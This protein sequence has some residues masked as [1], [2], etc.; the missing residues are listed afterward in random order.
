MTPEEAIRMSVTAH[1][2]N[3]SRKVLLMQLTNPADGFRC[4][5]CGVE[6][7]RSYASV[8]PDVAAK[9]LTAHRALT[10]SLAELDGL[11]AGRLRLDRDS[12]LDPIAG[13]MNGDRQSAHQ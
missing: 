7:A 13:A 11:T 6:L 5:F 12:V 9:V 8:A 10:A 2:G 4:P 1:C 3:C